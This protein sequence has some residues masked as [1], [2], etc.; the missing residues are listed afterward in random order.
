MIPLLASGAASLAS[1]LVNRAAGASSSSSGNVALDPK[2]FQKALSKAS[3]DRPDQ[4]PAQ[5]QAAALTHRL[6]HSPEVEAALSGQPAGSVNALEVR[7][8]GG[9]VLQTARGAVAVQLT[10]PSRILAQQVYAASALT[11]VTAVSGSVASAGGTQA[12]LRLPVQGSLLR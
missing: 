12:A 5:Q 6:M 2:A 10:E 3:Q 7:A 9:V 1:V 8:D 11:G 4:S